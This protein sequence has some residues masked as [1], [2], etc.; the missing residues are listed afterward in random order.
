ML[1]EGT[2]QLQYTN[3]SRSLNCG[4][5][6]CRRWPLHVI[7]GVQYLWSGH[8]Y[9]TWAPPV[10]DTLITTRRRS[11]Y[12]ITHSKGRMK[13]PLNPDGQQLNIA[14]TSKTE[15]SPESVLSSNWTDISSILSS[16]YFSWTDISSILP[17]VYLKIEGCQLGFLCLLL[18]L[19]HVS[20]WIRRQ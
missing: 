12:Y 14:R 1:V 19:P 4:Y 6:V 13:F 18:I 17:S 10:V 11:L 7:M 16:V 20:A 3:W 15:A 9:W 5:L 2:L 8:H